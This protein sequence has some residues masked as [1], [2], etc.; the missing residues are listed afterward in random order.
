MLATQKRG[1]AAILVK[2]L[3]IAP[4]LVDLVFYRLSWLQRSSGFSFGE[5]PAMR[6]RNVSY[7]SDCWRK[8]ISM[9]I[10]VRRGSDNRKEH[11]IRV[12]SLPQHNGEEGGIRVETDKKEVGSEGRM[13]LWAGKCP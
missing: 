9:Q 8:M 3:I 6:Y 12:S 1:R 2:Y 7:D 11:E 13:N 10:C 5:T 4:R